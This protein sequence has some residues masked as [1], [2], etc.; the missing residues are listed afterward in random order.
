MLFAAVAALV[1][2]IAVVLLIVISSVTVP[3]PKQLTLES[4][5]NTQILDRKSVV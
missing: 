3:A 2:I 1:V 5:A 4:S